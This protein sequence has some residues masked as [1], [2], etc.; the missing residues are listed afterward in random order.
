MNAKSLA[1][2]SGKG[3]SGK[4]TLG[5][6]LAALLSS[7]NIKVLLVDCDLSTHGATYFYEKHLSEK[8][9]KLCCFADLLYGDD[10]PRLNFLKISPYYDFLPSILS[11]TNKQNRNLTVNTSF[12]DN[13]YSKVS[14][15]Y[16]VIIF[17]CQAGYS[18]VLRHILPL[19]ELHLAVM[20]ADAISSSAMR[21]LY[22]KIGRFLDDKKTYQVFNKTTSEEYEVYSKL[23]GGTIFTN[24]ETI[25]F[26]WKIRKAFSVAQIPDIENTSADYG[27]QLLSVCNVLFPENSIQKKLKKFSVILEIHKHSEEIKVVS[28]RIE[29]INLTK[30]AQKKKSFRR[31]YLSTI[32]LCTLC[33]IVVYSLFFFRET[34]F[35]DATITFLVLSLILLCSLTTVVAFFNLFD[36]R[37]DQKHQYT[38]LWAY[39]EKLEALLTE[40]RMLTEKLNSI[41]KKGKRAKTTSK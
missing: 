27:T 3:G 17:D 35:S 10:T 25:M 41:N 14:S 22:L 13:F 11:I 38:Q 37:K 16:D 32:P 28:D 31:V 6:S 4:T 30:D 8:K 7:C 26:D 34:F 29:E 12:V 40:R 15:K 18:D 33:L 24:I 23:Y 20:E 19:V 39:R 1:L 5:L 21:S 2:I 36:S 9:D